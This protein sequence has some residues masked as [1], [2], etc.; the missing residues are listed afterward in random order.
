MFGEKRLQ[1]FIFIQDTYYKM[2]KQESV[3]VL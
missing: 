3:H 1:M 2:V